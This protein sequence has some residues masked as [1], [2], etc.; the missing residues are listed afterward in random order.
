MLK[1]PVCQGNIFGVCVFALFRHLSHF[2]REQEEGEGFGAGSE[3]QEGEQEVI[4]GLLAL[5]RK[6]EESAQEG[7]AY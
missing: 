3:S 4:F 5:H 6:A 7:S 1:L 2:R